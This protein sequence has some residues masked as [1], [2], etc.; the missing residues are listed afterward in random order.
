ML[1]SRGVLRREKGQ[2]ALMPASLEDAYTN[3]QA[4]RIYEPDPLGSREEKY[5][6]LKS[7]IS[8]ADNFLKKGMFLL[9]SLNAYP[10]ETEKEAFLTTAIQ[11]IEAKRSAY[12]HQK[13]K[14]E[15]ILEEEEHKQGLESFQEYQ[16]TQEA[17]KE[18]VMAL[19]AEAK[20]IF[21]QRGALCDSEGYYQHGGECWSDT[22]QQTFLN[23]DGLKE[24]M[25]RA[26][27]VYPQLDLRDLP[28]ALFTPMLLPIPGNPNQESLS[29]ENQKLVNDYIRDNHELIAQ[30]KQWVSLYLHEIQKRFLRHYL[31][32]AKRRVVDETCSLTHKEP[33]QKA[34]DEIAALSKLATGR[35]QGTEG[36]TSAILGKLGVFHKAT[37]TGETLAEFSGLATPS[38]ETYRDSSTPY[39]KGGDD[40]THAILLNLYNA[41]FFSNT[42]FFSRFFSAKDLRTFLSTSADE[43]LEKT[44]GIV[45]TTNIKDAT[46]KKQN[47]HMFSVY[48]CGGKE[49]LYDDNNGLIP[50]AW[51]VFL[52]TLYEMA[53]QKPK[54]HFVTYKRKTPRLR[55]V[56]EFYPVLVFPNQPSRYGIVL[57]GVYTAV[58]SLPYSSGTDQDQ[59]S[60]SIKRHQVMREM[61]LLHQSSSPSLQN[62]E[63]AFY[64]EARIGRLKNQ[65]LIAFMRD[66]SEGKNEDEAIQLLTTLNIPLTLTIPA[67]KTGVPYPLVYL[68]VRLQWPRFLEAL[69]QRGFDPN[70]KIE[71]G[72]RPGTTALMLAT[73]YKRGDLVDILL[74]KNADPTLADSNGLQA[75]HTAVLQGDLALLQKLLDAG[76]NVNAQTK[77]GVTPLFLA[78]SNDS[79]ELVQFLCSKDADQRLKGSAT[80]GGPLVLP[81]AMAKSLPVKSATMKCSLR[82][83]GTRTRLLKKGKRKT[84]RH[85]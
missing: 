22:L 2:R 63:Y 18:S 49:L 27:I 82:R 45:F 38:L 17:E 11:E 1:S 25:Q 71:G 44:R 24:I 15:A 67:P 7:A 56:S 69:L 13:Q 51:T 65:D 32:E 23:A 50:F 77:T 20:A 64:P 62:T 48:T 58:A 60:I 41:I 61:I 78:A 72:P 36:I 83:G 12:E 8:A 79:L 40:I 85:R 39:L 3:L 6:Q 10:E 68:A 75:I 52:K 30:Q 73:S 81:M 16:R 37:P 57:D 66:V 42:L 35:K 59:I 9:E 21:R 28:D 19:Q 53:D 4:I 55:M 34:L 43:V 84:R 54:V 31:T 5:T 46:G 26:L 33:G 74:K 80:E 76:A 29:Q 47:A 14:L 70:S